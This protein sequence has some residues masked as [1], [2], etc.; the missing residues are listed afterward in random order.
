MI[1]F[2]SFSYDSDFTPTDGSGTPAELYITD[3]GIRE[4]SNTIVMDELEIKGSAPG[5]KFP[6][7][8]LIAAGIAG[9]LNM[10]G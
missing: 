6:W 5:K 4:P 2:S 1:G 7:W 8:I 3:D 9:Y 10:R